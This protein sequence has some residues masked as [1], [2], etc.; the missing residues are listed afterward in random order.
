MG[1]CREVRVTVSMRWS[2]LIVVMKLMRWCRLM[3]RSREVF[4]ML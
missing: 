3:G 1:R 4:V 2:R